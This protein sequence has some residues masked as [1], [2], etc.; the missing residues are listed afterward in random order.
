MY[1]DFMTVYKDKFD[2]LC[3]N[4]IKLKTKGKRFNY[5]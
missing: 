4:N 1:G 5:D 3:Y 2:G